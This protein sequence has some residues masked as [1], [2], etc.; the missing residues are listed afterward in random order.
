MDTGEGEMCCALAQ[1]PSQLKTA[2]RGSKIRT[3]IDCGLHFCVAAHACV[4]TVPSP[5]QKHNDLSVQIGNLSRLSGDR[6]WPVDNGCL[7][8]LSSSCSYVRA[9]VMPTVCLSSYMECKECLTYF[10]GCVF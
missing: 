3:V 10:V 9:A 8:P 5:V 1:I 4:K 7:V 2:A 6:Q